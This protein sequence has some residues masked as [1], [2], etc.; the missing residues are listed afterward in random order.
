MDMKIAIAGI[1]QTKHED[2]KLASLDEIIFEAASKALADAG[3][4]RDDVDNVV[5]AASDQMDGRPI[6]SMTLACPAGAFL[7]DEIKVSDDGSSAIIMAC[8]R[9][10]SGAFDTALVVSWG[11][12]SEGPVDKVTHLSLDPFFHRDLG[13]NQVISL[14]LQ[15]GAYFNKFPAAE[16]ATGQVV[17][18]NRSNALRNPYAHLQKGVT[19]DE[20]R[21]SPM[22]AWPLRQLMLPPRSDGACAM[23][24]TTAEKA[25]KMAQ[26]P[27]WIKGMGWAIDGYYLGERALSELSSTAEAAKRAYQM[28]GI[29]DPLKELDV[30][31]ITEVSAFHELMAYEAL[32]LCEEGEGHRLISTGVTAQSGNL[33]VNPSGGSLSANPGY[34]TGLV[35]IAEAAIQIRGDAGERQIEGAKTALAMGCYG[36]SAQGSSVFILAEDE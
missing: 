31:E 6:S 20:V 28:A 2:G 19:L 3:I 29:K 24:I 12:S 15:A 35:R 1:A 5:I 7:K 17:A 18:K 32:G 33:P 27:V 16:N 11:K 30:A 36:L 10:L 34:A 9:I 21:E 13:L 14:A 23:I 26:K 22:K 25:K 8:L 4:T